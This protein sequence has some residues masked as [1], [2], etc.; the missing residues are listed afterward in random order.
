VGESV[1]MKKRKDLFFENRSLSVRQ[2]YALTS[3]LLN[4]RTFLDS[5]AMIN[6]KMV[7]I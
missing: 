2:F 1:E 4:S 7:L 5:S 6:A 3:V